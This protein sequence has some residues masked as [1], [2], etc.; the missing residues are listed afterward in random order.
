[1]SQRE[2]VIAFPTPPS[3]HT[4]H[5]IWGGDGYHDRYFRFDSRRVICEGRDEAQ[6]EVMVCQTPKGKR[7]TTTV[8]G[9]VILSP[10]EARAL[11]LSICP[12]L[13]PK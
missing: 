9:S 2:V 6:I 12:E 4:R 8:C 7:R 11:A 10:A 3:S 5:E 1:M 13:A